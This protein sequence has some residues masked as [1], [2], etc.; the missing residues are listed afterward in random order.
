MPS[1]AYH[2][3]R[4]STQYS[5]HSSSLPGL[6]EEL[7]LHL[8]ELA[9]AEGEVAR[10]DLVAERL[11][12]LRDAER[13][14][15]ARRIG[16]VDEVGEDALRRLRPQV[17]LG[18][19]VRHRPEMRLEHEVELARRRQLAFALRIGTDRRRDAGVLVLGI[20]LVDAIALLAL[21][22]VDHR[23]GEVGDVARRAPDHRV[24]QDRR[25]EADDVLAVAHHR[26][27]PGVFDVAL[28]LDAQW[29]V[30]PG[31]VDAAVELRRLKDEP[32]ALGHR[33]QLLHQL[34]GGDGHSAAT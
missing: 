17:G 25:V 6:H 11:A 19:G 26:L 9:R 29:T 30:I 20:D 13:H 8:L 14:L 7:H 31:A 3:L 22:A 27:P 28:E 16:H 10:V 21:L 18:R 23:V 4:C 33:D 15:D 24:H 34:F 2:F 12:D 5:N 1:D 32:G